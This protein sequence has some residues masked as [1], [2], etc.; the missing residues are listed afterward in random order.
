MIPNNL[1]PKLL[2][3]YLELEIICVCVLKIKLKT[4]SSLKEEICMNKNNSDYDFTYI[5]F[6]LIPILIKNF[7]LP[8][9]R[10]ITLILIINL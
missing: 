5:I 3:F 10:L 4:Y 9:N 2:G 6:P 7:Q 1:F 8:I